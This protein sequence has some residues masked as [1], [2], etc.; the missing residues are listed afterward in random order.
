MASKCDWE[1]LLPLH[2]QCLHKGIGASERREGNFMVRWREE[3]S[4]ISD[5]SIHVRAH[6]HTHAHAHT[7]THTHTH[8]N[9]YTQTYPL[10]I[11]A[12]TIGIASFS[13]AIIDVH[14]NVTQL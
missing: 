7:H 3:E 5:K 9:T 10:H 12:L 1:T 8:I 11:L 4:E 13:P 6:T 14:I 2:T